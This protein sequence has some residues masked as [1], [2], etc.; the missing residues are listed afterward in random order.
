MTREFVRQ[1]RVKASFLRKISMEGRFGWV[2]VNTRKDLFD[3]RHQ[4]IEG[5]VAVV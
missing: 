1:E 2:D 3:Q 4:W 5:V